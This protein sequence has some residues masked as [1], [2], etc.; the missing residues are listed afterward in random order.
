MVIAYIIEEKLLYRLVGYQ[1]NRRDRHVCAGE[2]FTI[3]FVDKGLFCS[4][5]L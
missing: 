4:A 3:N 2:V 5:S 1:C